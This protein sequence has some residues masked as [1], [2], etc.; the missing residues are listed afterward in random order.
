MSTSSHREYEFSPAQNEVFGALSSRMQGVGLFLVVV[1]I[2]NFLVAGLV[3]LAIYRTKL[4]E[5]YVKVVLEKASETTRTDLNAQL[6][7]LPPDNHLWG[8][9]ISNA[10]NGLL[11]L[12]IGVWTRSAAGSF[13]KIVETQGGDIHHLMEALTSLNKMYTLIYTLILLG[14][15][16]IVA[17]IALVVYAQMAR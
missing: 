6:S 1:A 11:Y 2:L 9:A 8:I 15:L 17:T 16:L 3:V 12:L 10:V 7:K 13:K 5:D 4:P 14:L